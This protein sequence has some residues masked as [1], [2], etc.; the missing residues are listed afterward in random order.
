MKHHCSACGA[1]FQREPGFFVGAIM[2]NIV[3]TEGLILAVYICSLLIPGV[4]YQSLLNVL[5]VLALCL[6]IAFYHHTWS[7]WLSFDH[8]LESLPTVNVTKL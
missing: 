4:N 8:L 1:L 2:V 7:V 5:F 6:P 3:F